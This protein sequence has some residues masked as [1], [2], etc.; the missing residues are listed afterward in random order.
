M[1]SSLIFGKVIPTALHGYA[2]MLCMDMHICIRNLLKTS[3]PFSS[4]NASHS[5]SLPMGVRICKRLQYYAHVVK[6]F[7]ELVRKY[8]IMESVLTLK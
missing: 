3:S 1:D 8:G 5:T 6:S 2:H 7:Y 4:W